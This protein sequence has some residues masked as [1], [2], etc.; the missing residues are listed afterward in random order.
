MPLAVSEIVST[1][2]RRRRPVIADTMSR[3]NAALFELRNRGRVEKQD[4]GRSILEMVMYGENQSFAFYYG[5]DPLNNSSQEVLTSAEY[6]WKQW[7]VGVSISGIEQL[8]NSGDSAVVSMLKQRIVNAEKTIT[9]RICQAIYSDGTGSAGKEIGGLALINPNASGATVGGIDSSTY[10]WWDN[11]RRATG[12][13]TKDNAYEHMKALTLSLTRG[14]D[15]VNLIISDNTY[16]LAFSMMAQLQQR[17]QDRKLAEVGFNTLNFEGIPVVA[18]GMLGGY[19]PVGMHFLNLQT[20]RFVMHAKRN[21][22][23]LEGAAKRPINEDS[24][25]V[26]MAGAG[27][28]T[29]NNRMLNGRLYN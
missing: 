8:M 20:F 29:T 23:V 11:A 10:T 5:L 3:N 28:M 15:K 17:F 14:M 7:A 27:N 24:E 25:T 22:V 9:N 18:D 4:G 19:A 12:G 16:Y 2:L 26:I 13:F 1:T 21:N 6:H